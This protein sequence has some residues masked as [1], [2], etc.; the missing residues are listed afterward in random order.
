MPI[1]SPSGHRGDDLMLQ[2]VSDLKV[3]RRS[4]EACAR[5]RRGL[6]MIIDQ[7][8]AIIWST[9]RELRFTRPRERAWRALAARRTGRRQT[10]YEYFDTDDPGV[11]PDRDAPPRRGGESGLLRLPLGRPHFETNVRPFYDAGGNIVGRSAA[12]S[13]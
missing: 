3:L 11:P 7:M 8:P 6:S 13:T 9:D 5:A 2:D 1:K 12:R 10:L 4:Q